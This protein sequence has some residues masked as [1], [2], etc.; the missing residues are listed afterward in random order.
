MITS[1]V[2]L[3][4]GLLIPKES[5]P[6]WFLDRAVV[7]SRYEDGDTIQLWSEVG[8]NMVKLP[9]Y[10][11]DLRYANLIDA[12]VEGRSL[13]FSI[14]TQCREGQRELIEKFDLQRR[15]GKRGFLVVA[16]TG[17]GKTFICINLINMLGR[18]ALVVVP[19]SDLLKQWVREL[20]LHTDLDE[21]SIGIGESGRIDWQ[22]KSVVIAI[23]DT[24]ARD[25]EGASFHQY[26]GTVV[27]DE[28]DRRI[29]ARTLNAVMGMLPARYRVA[30]T[31]TPRRRDGLDALIDYHI[32]ECRISTDLGKKMPAYIYAVYYNTPGLIFYHRG[33]KKIYQRAS[34]LKQITTDSARNFLVAKYAARLVKSGRRCAVVSDRI[35]Q[36]KEIDRF[37]GESFGFGRDKVGYYVKGAPG[38][39]Q[40]RKRALESCDVILATYGLFGAGTDV[41]TLS[42]LVLA[43]PQASATQVVGRVERYLE[44]K[45]QPIVV[46][47]VDTG[48]EQTLGWFNARLREYRQRNLKVEFYG[49]R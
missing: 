1:N 18:A 32:A 34:I 16:P 37:L 46:D 20:L 11:S 15:K 6:K 49:R 26:F 9:R 29:P 14:K 45:P 47:I 17:M 10:Y 36:L 39:E 12:T 22:D 30:I 43:S 21:S 24:V 5:L 38:N 7:T 25:R 2:V 3:T 8:S 23:A 33:S 27:F 41:P 44:G 48:T 31:A 42:S 19:K 40:E 28:V 35:A 4:S 13:S